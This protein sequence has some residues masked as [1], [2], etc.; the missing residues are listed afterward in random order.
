MLFLVL[1][2]FILITRVGDLFLLVL[3]WVFV[4]SRIVHAYVHTTSNDLDW[5][6]R[7]YALGVL[8]LIVMWVIFAVKILAGV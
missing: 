4:I 1:I 8:A 7:V 3:A 5:R 2:A 6:F